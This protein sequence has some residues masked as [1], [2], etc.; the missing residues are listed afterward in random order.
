MK[1]M[2]KLNQHDRPRLNPL[3]Y[4]MAFPLFRLLTNLWLLTTSAPVWRVACNARNA[5]ESWTQRGPRLLSRVL[6]EWRLADIMQWN[7][8]YRTLPPHEYQRSPSLPGLSDT[9]GAAQLWYP[10]LD[11][12]G[13]E[14]PLSNSLTLQSTLSWTVCAPCRLFSGPLIGTKHSEIDPRAEIG[15]I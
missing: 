4:N 15:A 14:S 1:S 9:T 7:W 5:R 8:I 2:S 6:S 12:C 11:N 3:D 13:D 10:D